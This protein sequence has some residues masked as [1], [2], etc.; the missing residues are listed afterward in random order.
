MICDEKKVSLNNGDLLTLRSPVSDDA[1]MLIDYMKTTTSETDFLMR[2]PEE[3]TITVEEETQYI[4]QVNNSDNDMMMVAVIDDE[5]VGACQ[6]GIG[7]RIKTSHKARVMIGLV[8]KV[9]GLGIGTIMLEQLIEV[10]RKHHLY[11]VELEYIGGN[12][13][14]KALYEK[15]GFIE[16]GIKPNAIRLKDGTMI[17]EIMMIKVL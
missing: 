6:I 15:M 13:R 16:T 11:Q 5:I 4:N 2:Y 17:D 1:A 7:V 10:A 12:N 14:A 9:W 8:K 3:V